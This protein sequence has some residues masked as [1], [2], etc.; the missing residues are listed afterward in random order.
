MAYVILVVAIGVE[1]IGT[2]LLKPSV[3]FTRLWPT[4]GSLTAYALAFVLVAQAV[5]RLP[6]SL[7]YAMW[8][9]LG[10]VAIAVIGAVFFG[11]S[12]SAV[13]V[14]GIM[15][16]IIGVVVLNLGEAH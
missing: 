8:S 12:L 15:L 13:K 16:V 4:V 5:K 3:G 10:T 9:G 1:V 7:V 2:S 6:V 11:E 14:V